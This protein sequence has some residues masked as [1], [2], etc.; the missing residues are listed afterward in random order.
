MSLEADTLVKIK[1]LLKTHSRGLTISDISSRSKMNRNSLAKYLEILEVSGQVE[2]RTF[3]TARV[4]LLS[5][6]VPVSAMMNTSSDLV[7]AL[8]ESN[9]VVQAND[10]FLEFLLARSGHGH[11]ETCHRDQRCKRDEPSVAGDLFGT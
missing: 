4:F 1:S 6:R 11:R 8:D 2:S 9:I 10:N 5:N 3:G 7:I